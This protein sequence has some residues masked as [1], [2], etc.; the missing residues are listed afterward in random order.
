ML[1][2]ARPGT[3]RIR[4]GNIGFS[5]RDSTTTNTA[6]SATAT[7]PNPSVWAESQPYSVALTIA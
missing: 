6:S 1:E 4:S 2:A 3:R 7:A 5:S